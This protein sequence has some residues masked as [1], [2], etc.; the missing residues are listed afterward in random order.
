MNSFT[1]DLITWIENNLERKLLLDDVSVKAGY[2]KWYLQR[3]FRAETGLALA[4]YIRHRKLYRAAIM[5]KMTSLSVIEITE[6]LGFST[7]QTLTRTF[8]RHFGQAPGRYRESALWN[9][10]GLIP[11]LTSGKPDLPCPQLVMARLQSMQGINLVYTCKSSQLD[12]E[13][14]HTEQRRKLL[15]V[16]R[17]KTQGNFPAYMAE[18]CEPMPGN[19][20]RIKFNLTFFSGLPQRYPSREDPE[21]FLCFPFRGSRDQLTE[22]QINIYRHIMPFRYESRRNGHDFF[23]REDEKELTEYNSVLHGSYYIPVSDTHNK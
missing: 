6:K 5:L 1:R 15:S 13:N 20:D 22:M 7:Q 2:S 8:K 11:K 19:S 17:E 16:V 21:A 10:E 12:S 9:F 18:S 4:S 14:F 3:L 23:I